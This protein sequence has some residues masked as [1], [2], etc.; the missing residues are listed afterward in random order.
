[1]DTSY[2]SLHQHI[3]HAG[4]PLN[5]LLDCTGLD[6]GLPEGVVGHLIDAPDNV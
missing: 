6:D 3:L 1:M 4:L 5:F 2:I